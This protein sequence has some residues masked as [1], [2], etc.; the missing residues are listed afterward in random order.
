MHDRTA[1]QPAKELTGQVPVTR[2]DSVHVHHL[3]HPDDLNVSM[4]FRSV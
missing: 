2:P 1:Q 3:S 4:D